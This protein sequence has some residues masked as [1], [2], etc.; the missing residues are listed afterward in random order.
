[1]SGRKSSSPGPPSPMKE[2]PLPQTS[3]PHRLCSPTPSHLIKSFLLQRTE[4]LVAAE[5]LGRGKDLAL[6]LSPSAGDAGAASDRALHLRT[7]T[8]R[9][10]KGPMYLPAPLTRDAPKLTSRLQRGCW[11]LPRIVTLNASSGGKTG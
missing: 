1:M 8:E 10:G 3:R 9:L 5:Q 6:A 4:S 7:C 2:T 11:D